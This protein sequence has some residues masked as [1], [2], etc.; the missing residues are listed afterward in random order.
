MEIN[1]QNPTAILFLVDQSHSMTEDLEGSGATKAQFV[2]DVLNRTFMELVAKSSKADGVRDYFHVGVLGYGHEGV[3][4]T[5]SGALANSVLSPVSIVS[6]NPVRVE[7][8]FQKISDGAGGIIEVEKKFPVWFEAHGNGA[9]PMCEAFGMAAKVLSDWCDDHPKSVAP[10]IIHVTDGMS[11]DGDPEQI[12]Q[13]VGTLSTDV[14]EV[15]VLN[16]HVAD[17][18]ARPIE[19]PNSESHLPDNYAKMLFRMSSE[20]PE[21]ILKYAATQGVALDAGA[22]GFLYQSDAQG[23]AQFFDFGTKAAEIVHEPTLPHSG[24]SDVLRIE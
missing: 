7:D 2:A 5:L 11:T 13:A 6:E 18:V 10:T 9:T 22:R 4:N 20:L 23:I 1:R 24:Q 14:G 16:L 21:N 17:Q 8:R 3:R 19:F 15:L 12:A